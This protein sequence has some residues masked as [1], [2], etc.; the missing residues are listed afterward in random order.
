MES[1]EIYDDIAKRTNGDIYVGVV[2]AVRTGKSTFIT[3]FMQSSILNNIKNQHEKQ[4]VIDEMPQSG[5]GTTVMTMQPKFVPNEAVEVDFGSGAKVRVRL[6]DCVGYAIDG[7]N[8]FFEDGQPRMVKTPWSDEEMPFEMAAEI[9][10]HKVIAEHST[11]AVLVATDGSITGIA[12]ANYEKSEERVVAELKENKKPF[13]VVL[14]SKS[15]NSPEV[16]SLADS[17]HEKYDAPVLPLDISKLDS[18]QITNIIKSILMEFPITKINFALPKWATALSYD[19]ELI[20]KVMETVKA[21]TENLE[22]MSDY[23]KMMKMFDSD[24]DIRLLEL[25]KLDMSNGEIDFSILFDESLYYKILSKECGVDISD[26]FN[27]MKIVKE[28]SCAKQEYDKLKTALDTVKE[29]GYGIVSPTVSELE[30]KD[31]EIITKGNSSS[32]RLKATAPS[33]HIMR[34]DVEAEICP[35]VGT[36]GQGGELMNQMMSE[37]EE[38]KQEIWNKNMFGKPMNELVKDSIDTKLAGLPDDVQVKMRKTITKI[39]NERKGGVICI[40]L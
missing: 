22:K 19:D 38:N 1:F 14:N 29:T 5:A 23:T 25:N 18:E 34:V 3:K 27:L 9:G 8:G 10:T 21:N 20:K 24:D 37:F 15:P 30:L 32:I 40:L 26:D 28:L 4:R 39:V 36:V 6:V 33:L 31:P 2:G 11:I 35:A 12:R 16:L 7:A 17:L 13:V